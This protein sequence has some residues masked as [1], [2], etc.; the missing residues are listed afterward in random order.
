MYISSTEKQNWLAILC[1]LLHLVLFFIVQNHE[2]SGS[3]ECALNVQYTVCLAC[4]AYCLSSLPQDP[5]LSHPCRCIWNLVV[6]NFISLSKKK[7]IRRLT[8][9]IQEL[10][11]LLQTPYVFFL[12]TQKATVLVTNLETLV[13]FPPSTMLTTCQSL[14]YPWL[15]AP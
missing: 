6:V 14:P 11:E 5:S 8:F 9:E 10:Q 4:L 3:K 15:F 2:K 7:S 1:F 12:V 13:W